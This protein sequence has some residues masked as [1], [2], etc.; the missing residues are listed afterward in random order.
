MQSGG[1][2]QSALG[3]G[4]ESSLSCY[5]VQYLVLYIP[6]SL[7]LIRSHPFPSGQVKPTY[8]SRRSE[9]RRALD[10]PKDINQSSS[11]KDKGEGDGNRDRGAQGD[12]QGLERDGHD[13]TV[14]DRGSGAGLSVS[15]LEE[16]SRAKAQTRLT[17]SRQT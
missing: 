5:T 6:S 17:S 16:K 14:V 10:I 3:E 4:G 15:L 1:T 11:T 7:I 2:I 13:D 8:L 12:D 9:L